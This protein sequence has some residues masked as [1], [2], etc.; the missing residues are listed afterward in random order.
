[1][2][3][4]KLLITAAL[5]LFSGMAYNQ[6]A[7]KD[8][9]TVQTRIADLLA[10]M[11]ASDP[12]Y[13]V[14]LMNGM[15]SLGEDGLVEIAGM[16]TPTGKGND[17]S[18]RFAVGGFSNFVMSP[19][20]DE[21]RILCQKAW[22]RALDNATDP[23]IKAFLMAQL[24]VAGSDM[25]V[26]C[27]EKYLIV[28]QL[29]D[30][31]ARALSAINTPS[32]GKALYAALGHLQGPSQISVVEA[33]GNMPYTESGPGITL[34]VNSPDQSLRKVALYALARFGMP[35]SAS[36][37]Y[38][39]ALKSG[40]VYEPV[41][42]TGSY[43]LWISRLIE[44]GQSA[45]AEKQCLG[46]LKTCIADNQVQTRSEALSLLVNASGDKATRHLYDA[47]QSNNPQ[48]RAAALNLAHQLKGEEQTMGWVKK[49]GKMKG[50][51]KAGIITM[52]GERGD[53]AALPAVLQCL[54]DEEE[55]VRLA[56]IAA[57]SK[58]GGGS[59]LAS[60]LE[61][62]KKDNPVEVDAV[63]AQLLTFGGSGFITAIASALPDMPAH[64]KTALI[65][66]LAARGSIEHADLV[67]QQTGSAEG[68]VRLAAF[69]AL[70]ALVS[71]N[72]MDQLFAL[73][74]RLNGPEEIAAWQSGVVAAVR[75]LPADR[76]TKVV[77]ATQQRYPET[78]YKLL[79]GI[80]AGIGSDQALK[81]TAGDFKAGRSGLKEAAFKALADWKYPNAIGELYG[82]G[83]PAENAA[84]RETALKSCIRLIRNSD[85]PDDQRLLLLRKVMD[86]A[87]GSDDKSLVLK[88][89]A[90]CNTYPS[91]RFA[92]GYLDDP[93]LQQ[94]AAR[95][96]SAIALDNDSFMGDDIREVLQKCINI[97]S[98]P[99]SEYQKEAIRKHLA[100]MP[101]GTGFVPL[102]NGK[103]LSGWKGLV[104]NPVVRAAMKPADLAKAQVRADEI[105]Q[106]G[107]K[108]ENGI[109]VFTGEGE[110][111]CTTQTY[112]DF[113]MFVDWKITS[114]GDA[115]IYLRG[116]P[117]VQIW[118]TSRRDA[119]AQVGS[120]G[121]YNNE[122]HERIP[123]KVAD[124]AIGDWNTFRIIMQ[125]ERVTVYLNGVLVV[126]H[127]I[128]ENYWDRSIPIF[129]TEQIE[130][131]AHGTWVGYRDINI[132]EIPR[133]EPYRVSE[134]E[135]AAGYVELFDGLSMFNWTGNTRDYV[136]EDGCIA[137]YPK[138]GGKGNLYTKEEYSDFS[139]RFEFQLTPGANNGI[140]IR[141][142]LEGDA[143]YAGM[144]IQ[145]L[146]NTAE[147][148]RNLKEYQYHGSVYG[149]IPAKREYLKPV[150][151]WN[152]EEIMAQGSH[153]RVTLNGTV[154]VDGDIAEA[155]RNG[156]L[157]HNEHPGLLNTTGHIGFLGHG[158]ELKFR[159]LRI[160]DLTK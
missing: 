93:A 16:L 99:E 53:P 79:Y 46:L 44:N 28:D 130:L 5:V 92:A 78:D 81:A 87:S 49:A 31:A 82:I 154:I 26:P 148:Y 37:L 63:K 109:L 83:L 25:A 104:E 32:A 94:D 66:I 42:A 11:P 23:E 157:D 22:C 60:L 41:Q 151:E 47:M 20:Q 73:V 9:R 117:Q 160:K 153:I 59:V 80:F 86:L 105:M 142:P 74:P 13:L 69:K 52:L 128:M 144:E 21:N 61:V 100:A 146:D 135:K 67:M 96:V 51:P 33:L 72:D 137:V 115:G 110:N 91:L 54:Q 122:V 132:R 36:L 75:D 156:T 10:Q 35:G 140:G 88:E 113:E 7:V 3:R 131:Q 147:I 112:G 159:N 123:L 143:A 62:L 121:L 4:K 64:A 127:V 149:V 27:L 76:Q 150:G 102:F 90:T 68:M 45:L 103:D 118:D 24:Q 6:E 29:C 34:L 138:Y 38:D 108:V 119:G 55:S 58:L 145:V 120:G 12:G 106:K 71:L 18:V 57:S 77:I 155:A 70:P 17:A 139:F 8:N 89:A 116:S 124:N 125:G 30:P 158:S 126:D 133:P 65:E 56:A 85:Y 1:M 136:V 84:Y 95:A 48:Y 101:Q 97:L 141:A 50:Q 39:A 111:L 129:S 107:W 114:Q 134:E 152:S 98:G 15:A 2:I 19:G 40:F 43:L 14:T